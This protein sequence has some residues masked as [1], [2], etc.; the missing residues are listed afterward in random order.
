[1]IFIKTKR[2][3]IRPLKKS[4]AVVLKNLGNNKKVWENMVDSFPHP[5]TLD[6][7]HKFI[8]SNQNNPSDFAIT[9]KNRKALSL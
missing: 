1:M 8:E 4:D 3:L 9:R 7:A 2:L 5:Y 6:D